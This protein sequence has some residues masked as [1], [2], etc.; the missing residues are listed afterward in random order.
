MAP[1][2]AAGLSPAAAAPGLADRVLATRPARPSWARLVAV[3]GID[4]SG[5]GLL[6]GALA[7]E[8]EA[9]G[10]R[11]ATIGLDDWHE[12]P[13]V[14]FGTPPGEH[15][16]RNAFD[17]ERLFS[18]VIEPLQ[19]HRA[20]RLEAVRPHPHTGRPLEIAYDFFDVDVVLVEGVFLLRR[21]LA[22]Y[23]DV[24]L[25]VDC[26]F[27]TALARALAR[28]QEGLPEDRLRA[29]YAR[30]YFPAQRLHESLDRPRAA[31]DVVV[32]ND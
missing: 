11:V 26:S 27:A 4:A 22:P 32:P 17:F 1:H 18:H 24:R 2:V 12:P 9:R 7:A 21:D 20:L 8:L 30:I 28:N 6:A 19:A 10:R 16:Y 13:E 31:A 15:F 5:K 29:D 14:R 3:S 23:Y 25:W